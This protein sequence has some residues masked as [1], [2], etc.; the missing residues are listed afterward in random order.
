MRVIS[1]IARGTKLKS[2]DSISTRPTLDRVKESLFNILMPKIKEAVI[3][4]LFAGSGAIA[5]EFLSRGAECA[6]L[7][8]K[9]H[10]AIK[11]I[12]ENLEKTKLTSKAKVIEKDYKKALDLLQKEKIQFDLVYIDPP[13][14]ANLAVDAV[15]KILSLNLLKEKGNLIIETDDEKRELLELEKL[16]INVYDIR[17]YGRVS[18]IF[19]AVEK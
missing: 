4:D 18:L 13:Y 8:E 7:C 10:L 15:E 11:M 5:I 1:G 19:L 9:S 2:I 14:A 16:D 12:Y 3:L 6:Y 17:K